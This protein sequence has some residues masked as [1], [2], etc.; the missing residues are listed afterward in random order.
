MT[1]SE[2]AAVRVLGMAETGGR[3]PVCLGVVDGRQHAHV[4]G[5]TGSGKSTLLGNLILADTAAGRG[6]VVIDPKGDLVDD[7]L[8]RLPQRSLGRLVVIDPGET[9][10][11]AALNVLDGADAEVAVDQV[12][13]VFARIFSAWWGPRTDD[14]L[15]SA[16]ATLVL[17]PGA[18]LADVPRLLTDAG[19]RAPLVAQI[20]SGARRDAAGLSGFWDHFEALSAGGQAQVIGPVMNKL[21]AVLG[22][23]FAR[24]LLGTVRSSFDMAAILDGGTLLVRLPKGKIGEDTARLVGSL[25]IART[26][27]AAT[28][29]AGQATRPDAVAYVDECQNFLNLP[30]TL[31]DV[32]AEA[33]GYHLGLVLAHQH[34]GQLPRDLAEAISANARNKIYFSCSPEDARVLARHTEPAVAATALSRLGDHRIAVRL[35]RAG[36]DLSAF[37]L[38]TRPM[39]PAIPGRADAARAAARVNAGRTPTQRRAEE[40]ARIRAHRRPGPSSVSGGVSGGVSDGAAET[41]DPGAAQGQHSRP[42]PPSSVDPDSWSQS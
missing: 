8:A 31:A 7:I 19:W 28:A 38:A 4:L 42:V 23:S 25:V 27:Q 37:T 34:L 21:R 12:C 35:V 14:V 30:G 26:W 17:L 9:A 15:R 1:P 5:A 2:I 16:L 24:N 36:R 32:L 22:R 10:A 33:R 39:P 6:V 11:P 41:T 3:R 29:R 20:S 13:G 18:T 40:L